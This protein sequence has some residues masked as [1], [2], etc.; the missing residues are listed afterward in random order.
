MYDK[1]RVDMVAYQADKQKVWEVMQS[2]HHSKNK[3]TIFWILLYFTVPQTPQKG[4]ET[5][6]STKMPVASQT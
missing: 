3:M 2:R 5:G 1:A 6:M 4:L